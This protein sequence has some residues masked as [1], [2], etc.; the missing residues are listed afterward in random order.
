MKVV[1]H[2][3]AARDLDVRRPR[4]KPDLLAA[5]LPVGQRDPPQACIGFGPGRQA[6]R[7]QADVDVAKHDL[8]DMGV[9]RGQDEVEVGRILLHEGEL[10]PVVLAVVNATACRVFGVLCIAVFTY[11][12]LHHISNVIP[13]EGPPAHPGPEEDQPH[14]GG[15]RHRLSPDTPREPLA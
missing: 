15:D 7:H 8:G 1:V 13:Q 10:A 11:R 12:H 5:P 14:R 2:E 3:S 4:V 6:G 9:L